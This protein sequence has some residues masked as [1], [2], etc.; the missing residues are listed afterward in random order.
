ML[1]KTE[2]KPHLV[3]SACQNA[4][5]DKDLLNLSTKVD[6]YIILEQK[7]QYIFQKMYHNIYITTSVIVFYKITLLL[8]C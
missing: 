6:I 2:V 7:C 1:S 3:L 5:L 8:G 4:L